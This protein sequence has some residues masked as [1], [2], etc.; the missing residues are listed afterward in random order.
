MGHWGPLWD[1]WGRLSGYVLPMKRLIV[2][3]FLVSVVIGIGLLH[4]ALNK[5][6]YPEWAFIE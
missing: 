6:L 4:S 2:P 5:P 1:V 3:V